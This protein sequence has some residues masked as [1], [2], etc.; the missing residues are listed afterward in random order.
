MAT[1][2]TRRFG[3]QQNLLP[4]RTGQVSKSL[5]CWYC[6]WK[7]RAFNEKL[8]FIGHRYARLLQV[9]FTIGSAFSLVA[10]VGVAALLIH[11]LGRAFYL[12]NWT[13]GLNNLSVSWLFG[14]SP[15]SFGLS[16][17]IMNAAVMFFSTTFAVAIH[18]FGH[19]VAAAS[20]GIQIEYIAIFLAIVFPGALVAINYDM[21]NSLPWFA[22]LR[23]Y[24]A[25]IWHN[26]VFCAVCWIMMF[27]L[28]FVLSPLYVHGEAPTVLEVP[29]TSALSGYLSHGDVIT[30][31]DGSRI[32]YPSDWTKKMIQINSQ[33][34][35]TTF[36]GKKGYCVPHSW[37]VETNI[38]RRIEDNFSCPGELAIFASI[39][40]LSSSLSDGIRNED[41]NANRTV[42]KQCLNAKYVIKLKKCGDGW[43][44]TGSDQT[45]CACLEHESCM[46]PVQ[47]IGTSWVEISYST[48]YSPECLQLSK[49]TSAN[50]DDIS[51]ACGG[52]FVFIG[53]VL[54]LAYSIHLSIYQP[55]WVYL[56][57][58]IPTL[59]ESILSCTFHV[60]AT[61]GV[62]NSLPV[63]F[64]DGESIL[65]V[66]LHYIT[67]LNPR[68]RRKVL[69]LFL[70]G[71]TILSI[72]VFSRILYAMFTLSA[73]Y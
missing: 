15:P 40:C 68:R 8:F 62:L 46:T 43:E 66:S 65:E 41:R 57:A 25:G 52:T 36:S 56:S 60:S 42:T 50:S 9:W 18:E 16:I 37:L 73:D 10:L 71:G 21:L 24:C 5:S 72:I 19:A 47:I 63:F 30:A 67:W 49:N 53:N 31:V 17:W 1:R 45:S 13:Y 2:R 23:I 51:S 70:V 64:L 11:E 27:L 29:Q 61:L 39:P 59:V 22:A 55:R 20:E 4:L 26:I 48:P 14:T 7:I 58:T 28:P 35:Q 38:T 54:T 33:M 69:R 3:R 6:D 34:L 12:H 44:V 32:R